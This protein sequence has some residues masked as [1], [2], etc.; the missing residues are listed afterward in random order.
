[1][2]IYEP[3]MA[4]NFILYFFFPFMTEHDFP[5]PDPDLPLACPFAA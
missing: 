5:P 1:M 2:Y 3:G 4:G